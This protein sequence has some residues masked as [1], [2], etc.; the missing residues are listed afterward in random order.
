[1]YKRLA[2][3]YRNSTITIKS[4]SIL[5]SN[6]ISISGSLGDD[7]YEE[8]DNKLIKTRPQIEELACLEKVLLTDPLEDLTTDEKRLLFICRDH[9]KSLPLALPL[10]LKSI[11]WTRSLQVREAHQIIDQ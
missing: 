7:P 10:F 8:E 5:A 4:K 2:K 6:H 9:Y 1:M 11:N 3:P